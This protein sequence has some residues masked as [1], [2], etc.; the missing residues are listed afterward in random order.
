[1]EPLDEVLSLLVAAPEETLISGEAMAR[2]L[3][4]SRMAVSGRISRLQQAGWH[5]QA[6]PRRGYR[7]L[8]GDR[9]DPILWQDALR[10]MALGRGDVSFS[11]AVA[12][13]NTQMKA[14]AVAGAPHGSICLAEAQTAG[15]GRLGR[16]WYSPA[17][18]GLWLSVLLRPNLPAAQAPLLTLCAAL[19]MA[20]GVGDVSAFRLSIKW[21]NDLVHHG[22][23]VCGILTEVAMDPD[24]I[25]YVVVGTGLNVGKHAYPPELA[26]QATSLADGGT[27]PLRRQ[28]LAA[29]LAR[30]EQWVDFLC[31]EGP[32]ALADAFA[33]RC[34]TLGQPVQVS[35]S[36]TLTGVAEGIGADGS[37]L[38]RAQ[39][40]ELHAVLS[41]DV[42]VRGVMG[43]V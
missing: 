17:G 27:P 42:S 43:Y 3:G 33:P 20:D 31:R 16:P 5:I 14:L 41:G 25:D 32:Q 1:M 30:M 4:I 36:V 9:I 10:T 37:L 28:V 21:P 24:G 8:A 22:K 40:G 19:A 34:I 39:D 13:T 6:V 11:M 29:Y 26:H 12:S 7:L 35:G 2:H 23:K 18:E 15:R 38:V